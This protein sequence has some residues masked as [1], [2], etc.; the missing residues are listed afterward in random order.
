MENLETKQDR[1]SGDKSHQTRA[2]SLPN[3]QSVSP[4]FSTANLPRWL[5]HYRALGFE[6]RSYGNEYGFATRDGI[7][8][9]VSVN[10]E[11]DPLRGAGC[12]YLYVE[13]ADALHALWS[14]A[15]AATSDMAIDAAGEGAAG[16][17]VAGA[18]SYTRDVAPVNTSY[19][20]REGA[21]LDPDNNLLRYGSE[22]KITKKE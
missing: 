15:A 17:D 10:S 20:L 12:A 16:G 18:V 9:H 5:S 7:Q 13:D 11:H 22:I 14:A 4:V 21:H 2:M 1:T 19:G 6:V 3:F 8:L